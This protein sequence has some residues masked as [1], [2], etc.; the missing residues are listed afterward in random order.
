MDLFLFEYLIVKKGNVCCSQVTFLDFRKADFIILRK[1]TIFYCV[2]KELKS[3]LLQ[4]N[5]LEIYI[6]SK[7]QDNPDKEQKYDFVRSVLIKF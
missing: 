2:A 3:K 4:R 6:L 7:H 1:L 5:F